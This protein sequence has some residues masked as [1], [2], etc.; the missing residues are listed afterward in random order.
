MK[1]QR[2]KQKRFKKSGLNEENVL[3]T[4]RQRIPTDRFLN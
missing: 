2:T 1:E 3:T 4:K